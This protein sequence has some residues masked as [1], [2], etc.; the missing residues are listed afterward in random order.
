MTE[1]TLI[2][3]FLALFFASIVFFMYVFV[4]AAF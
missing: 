1:M 4:E 3:N 2:A